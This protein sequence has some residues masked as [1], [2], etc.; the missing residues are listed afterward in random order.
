MQWIYESSQFVLKLHTYTLYTCNRYMHPSRS[1]DSITSAHNIITTT[2]LERKL[3][4]Y[5]CCIENVL[6]QAQS[7]T[8][9]QLQ[10]DMWLFYQSIQFYCY[11]H[12]PNVWRWVLS[13][14]PSS[15][16]HHSLLYFGIWSGLTCQL[17][18]ANITSKP[19]NKTN[20]TE[21]GCYSMTENQHSNNILLWS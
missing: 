6:M 9:Q 15:L 16:H 19:N 21:E 1:L 4:A 7:I 13:L 10:R 3:I 11:K 8:Y 17:S 14:S 12:W 20:F 18:K 5:H 2:S